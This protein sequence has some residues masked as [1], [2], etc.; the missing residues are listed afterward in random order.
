MRNSIILIPARL[1]ATRL[2]NKPLLKINNKSIIM[3]VYQ[4]AIE[5]EI[6][7]VYVTSCD[8]LIIDEVKKNGG[9]SILTSK[10][11]NTGTDRIAEALDKIKLEYEVDY[12]INLQGDEPLI[13]ISDIRNLKNH[14]ININSD[15]ATLACKIDILD[16]STY[17]NTNVVKVVTKDDLL[18]KSVS[19]AIK[20]ERII[21]IK[22]NKYTYQHIGIYIFKKS[23]LKNFIKLDQTKKEKEKKLEQL[24]ALENGINIDVILAKTIPIGVDTKEDYLEIK[25][26]VEY[27]K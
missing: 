9:K 21:D 13:N 15:M 16:Q 24:R 19:R 6:G 4:K 20:F 17:N 18:E 11:H 10:D 23:I 7:D 2:P 22:T 25:K 8:N 26:L 5:C 3:H 12:I 1:A 27:K 14:A